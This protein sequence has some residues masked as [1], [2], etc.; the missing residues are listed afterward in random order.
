MKKPHDWGFFI[1]RRRASD[2]RHLRAGFE[3]V[4]S[5]L[6]RILVLSKWETGTAAVSRETPAAGAELDEPRQKPRFCLYL[7]RFPSDC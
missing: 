2:L 7:Q 1:W 5:Y 6:R 3:A 4:L